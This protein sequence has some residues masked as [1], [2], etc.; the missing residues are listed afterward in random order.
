M[1]VKTAKYAKKVRQLGQ[2]L[3]NGVG[4][5]GG[6][7][8]EILHAIENFVLPL[9]CAARDFDPYPQEWSACFDEVD[10]HA[11]E[12]I[13]ELNDKH[14]DYVEKLTK[15]VATTA[16]DATGEWRVNPCKAQE[17]ANDFY[18]YLDGLAAPRLD[19]KRSSRAA[20]RYPADR[21]AVEILKEALRIKSEN[22]KMTDAGI[23][24]CMLEHQKFASRILHGPIL[25]GGKRKDVQPK[26]R[27]TCCRTWGGY[28][29]AFRRD[30][31]R[32]GRERERQG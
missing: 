29:S 1:L 12:R 18:L 30:P 17:A 8:D 24:S 7:T 14:H 11:H 9:E 27:V 23:I 22:P 32:Q 28:L 31:E 5:A 2:W 6:T 19:G 26:D 16:T 13:K 15:L 4:K 20:R 10:A 3:A 25:K 21:E